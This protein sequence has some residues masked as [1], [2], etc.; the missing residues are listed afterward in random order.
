MPGQDV[1]CRLLGYE[2]DTSP[3]YQ[4]GGFIPSDCLRFKLR[5]GVGVPVFASRLTTTTIKGT[6]IAKDEA[7]E[8]IPLSNTTQWHNCRV[9]SPITGWTTVMVTISKGCSHSHLQQ[10]SVYGSGWPSLW[11]YIET[12]AFLY[13][14]FCSVGRHGSGTLQYFHGLGN[15]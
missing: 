4:P 1:N 5:W 15:G 13:E 6:E 2:A 14:I 12:E 10:T 9:I 7:S 3:L 8:V 11:I